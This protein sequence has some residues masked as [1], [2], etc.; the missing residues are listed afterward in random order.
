MMM[1]SWY[2]A[3]L[4]QHHPGVHFPGRWWDPVH[5]EEKDTF[6]LEQFLSHNTQ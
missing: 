6:S 3:K 5:T 2:V 1:Y 4:G